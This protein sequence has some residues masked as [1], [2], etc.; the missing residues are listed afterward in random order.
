VCTGPLSPGRFWDSAMVTPPGPLQNMPPFSQDLGRRKDIFCVCAISCKQFLLLRD[1]FQDRLPSPKR[2]CP[3]TVYFRGRQTVSWVC[4]YYIPLLQTGNIAP[5]DGLARDPIPRL[6]GGRRD[7]PDGH[8]YPPC[9]PHL[10]VP[11][12]SI[13]ASC[14]PCYL[15][16]GWDIAAV[17]RLT[18]V[19]W[20]R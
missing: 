3:Y 13:F 2:H 12:A 7:G 17:T 5:A 6:G 16:L 20:L 4:T 18:L 9:M 19:V 11:F 8:H 14:G 10:H 15:P 1:L